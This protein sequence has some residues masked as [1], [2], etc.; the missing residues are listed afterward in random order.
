MSPVPGLTQAHLVDHSSLP[1]FL[2][3]VTVTAKRPLLLKPLEGPGTTLLSR[4]FSKDRAILSL[5]LVLVGSGL[6]VS[7][8]SRPDPNIPAKRIPSP[9]VRPFSKA[10]TEG[11]D[12]K[13]T[14]PLSPFSCATH[15]RASSA[16]AR[17]QSL[18]KGRRMFTGPRGAAT[19]F[20]HEA[21][22]TLHLGRSVTY[23]Q[24][25]QVSVNV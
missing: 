18:S 7:H 25:G 5:P 24:L 12:G 4:L 23:V 2:S 13:K 10:R 19:A 8:L 21:M 14:K 11:R 16:H 22:L 20:P 6:E 9:R 17:F 1:L 3:K 15:L